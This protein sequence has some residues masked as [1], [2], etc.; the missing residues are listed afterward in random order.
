MKPSLLCI[1]AIALSPL[2]LVSCSTTPVT[3]RSQ[4][5]LTSDAKVAEMTIVAFE[6]MK[7]QMPISK[8]PIYNEMLQTVGERISQQV[9]WDMPMAEWE[10]VVFDQPEINAFAMPGGKVGVFE[11]LFQ[12]AKTE[13][14]LASVVAHE[15]AH[16][17]A[18][19]THERLSQQMLLNTGGQVVGIAAAIAGPTSLGNGAYV[20]M[21]GAIMGIYGMGAQGA[22]VAWDRG[23]EAEAD[24]I[25]IMYMAKAGYDPS[26]AIT[27]ME[28][29][30]EM[31]AMRGGNT[32]NSTHPSSADRLDLLHSYLEEAMQ[33][34]EK[35][36][37]FL[38]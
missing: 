33:E 8:D 25:G 3:G 6:Q 10:F 12:I 27:V 31:E 29:M 18:R 9:F 15:I 30:V 19:H 35:A 5:N 17:T 21:T 37:E 20:N 16:V 13:D 14:E 32:Y 23:K 26:A 38:Y 36:K 2:L 7:S 24:Q 4:L 34:Y 1:V 11:G 28:R 22:A